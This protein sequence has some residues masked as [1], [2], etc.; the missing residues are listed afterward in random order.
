MFELGRMT[1]VVDLMSALWDNQLRHGDEAAPM[2]ETQ[3][4]TDA[5]VHLALTLVRWFTSGAVKR[6]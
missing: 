3:E 6:A 4:A 1:I 2:S 5:A